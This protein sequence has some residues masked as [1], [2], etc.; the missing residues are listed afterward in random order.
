MTLVTMSV[1][2]G[3]ILPPLGAVATTLLGVFAGSAVGDRSRRM[4]W[5]HDQ[6]ADACAAV[7]RES[8]NL[9]FELA[10]LNHSLTAPAPDGATVPTVLDWRKWNDALAMVNLVA[11]HAIVSAAIAID[12][13][14]WPVS[15]QVQRGWVS[16]DGWATLRDRVEAKRIDFV[17]AARGKLNAAGPPVHRLTG[18]PS[19]SDPFWQMRRANFEL[20]PQQA[21]SPPP[22]V[23]EAAPTVEGGAEH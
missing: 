13:Q 9:L 16:D 5:S 8:S 12:E 7:L 10:R 20:E 22:K 6:Q 3:A 23:G 11:D 21:V 4:Q 18:R 17:N 19:S 14:F 2:L 1:D 15:R